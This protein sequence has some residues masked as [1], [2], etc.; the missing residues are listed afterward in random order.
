MIWDRIRKIKIAR[1]KEKKV[2]RIVEMMKKA[3]VKVLRSNEWQV[4]GDSVLK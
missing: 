4:E 3:G 1:G 2:V